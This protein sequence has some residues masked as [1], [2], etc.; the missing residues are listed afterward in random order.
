MRHDERAAAPAARRAAVQAT[1]VAAMPPTAICPSP[2]TLV[3]LAR[4]AITKPRPTRPSA[5]ARLIDAADRVRRAPGA[6]GER[7]ERLRHRDAD[8]DDQQPS[9]TA[10]AATHR[11]ERRPGSPAGRARAW[12]S[13]IAVL[14]SAFMPRA[15]PSWRRCARAPPRSAAHSPIMRPRYIT[16]MRSATR[17]Q[18]VELGGDQQHADAALAGGAD[19]AVDRLDRADVEA[20]RRLRGE[21]EHAGP[22]GSARAPAPPSAGCRPTGWR[23]ATSGPAART[24]KRCI[25]SLAARRSARAVEQAEAAEVARA[26]SSIRFSARLIGGDAADG[27]PVLGHDA[28]AGRGERPSAWRR[29][30]SRPPTKTRP[31]LAGAMPDSTAPSSLWPLPSTPAMPTISPRVDDERRRRRAGARRSASRT[32]RPSTCS[33]SSAAG[34]ASRGASRDRAEAASTRGL[35]AERSRWRTAPRPS[36]SRWII[37]RTSAADLLAP[38]PPSARPRGRGAAP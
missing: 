36:R 15:P 25:V 20:A 8:A 24:S 14:A 12:R 2:P 26:G 13:R 5:S 27:V 6:V 32:V 7:G 16:T 4:C 22:A 1:A 33:A 34:S 28:D 38:A 3:R 10:S 30:S 35:G 29:S 37:A 23:T 31:S 11:G 19:L 9:R 17:E 18:L 21:Q